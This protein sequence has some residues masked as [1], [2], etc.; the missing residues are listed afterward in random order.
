MIICKRFCSVIDLERCEDG[1]VENPH[2]VNVA[3]NKAHNEKILQGVW[4]RGCRRG[5]AA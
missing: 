5:R 2:S 3:C 4:T 1:K